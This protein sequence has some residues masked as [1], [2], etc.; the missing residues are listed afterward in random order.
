MEKIIFISNLLWWIFMSIMLLGIFWGVSRIIAKESNSGYWV[1]SA[2]TLKI[3]IIYLVVI[4]III[5]KFLV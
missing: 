1:K 4:Y 2:K 3:I 5:V